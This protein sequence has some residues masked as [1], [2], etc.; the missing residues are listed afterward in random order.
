MAKSQ[1]NCSED[2]IVSFPLR[3]RRSLIDN[4]KKVARG[5]YKRSLNKHL[6]LL[7]EENVKNVQLKKDGS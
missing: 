6:E 7:L 3:T 1:S 5:G 2:P 4:G